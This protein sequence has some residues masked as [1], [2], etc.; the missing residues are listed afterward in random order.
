[1]II[2]NVWAICLFRAD[3][4]KINRLNKYKECID[5]NV[6]HIIFKLASEIFSY[7]SSCVFIVFE[8]NAAN[9]A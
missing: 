3:Y 2:Q 7:D 8:Y 6:I 1:M 4:L 5:F 9:I